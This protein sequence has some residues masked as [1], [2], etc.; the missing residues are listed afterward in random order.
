MRKII[1]EGECAFLRRRRI[2]VMEKEEIFGE[3]KYIFC[4]ETGREK[5]ANIWKCKIY[6]L[7]R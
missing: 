7:E 1:G 4:K 2:A 3:G 5:M 6:F